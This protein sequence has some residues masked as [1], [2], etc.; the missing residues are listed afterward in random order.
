MEYKIIN[1]GNKGTSINII[2]ILKNIVI[3]YVIT[4]ILLIV[5]AFIIT[6]S[7]IPQQWISPITFIITT[8]SIVFASLLSGK[9][10]SSKGWLTG[11][12]SGLLYM[13][14]LYIFGSL[15]FHNFHLG[16]NAQYMLISGAIS[17]IAGGI[18]GINNKNKRKK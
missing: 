13:L 12:I 2:N 5:L 14:I 18:I 3:S 15:I 4:F 11:I 16:T 6:Y 10:T 9:R 8:I 17:G 1:S 7:D